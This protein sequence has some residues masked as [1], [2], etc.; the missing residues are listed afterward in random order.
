MK[1]PLLSK[2][3]PYC[4]S[5]CEWIQLKKTKHTTKQK[6]PTRK[7]EVLHPHWFFFCLVSCYEPLWMVTAL[8]LSPRLPSS[9]LSESGFSVELFPDPPTNLSLPFCTSWLATFKE[10]ALKMKR[11]QKSHQ[12]PF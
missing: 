1:H 10:D 3:K 12:V 2:G 11:L 9:W 8:L 5:W 7:R 4:S 6:S